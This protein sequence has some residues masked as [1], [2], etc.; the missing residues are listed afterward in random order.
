[1][2]S[3]RRWRAIGTLLAAPCLY[4]LLSGN[5]GCMDNGSYTKENSQVENQQNQYVQNQPPPFFDWSLERHIAIKLYE[6]RNKAVNT[7]S[8]VRNQY[9]GKITSWCPSMGFP[10]AAN[11]QL[12]NPHMVPKDDSLQGGHVID[13]PEPNGLFSSPSTRGTFVMCLG[14]DGMLIPRYHE[15]DV[16]VYV[17]PMV[18]KDGELVPVEGAVPSITIDPTRPPSKN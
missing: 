15:A 3:K 10:I 1:M 6:A 8:Y 13:Q 9:T 7:Y 2:D 4:L 5:S 18:E 16:E 14:K 11:T 17:T 12:T